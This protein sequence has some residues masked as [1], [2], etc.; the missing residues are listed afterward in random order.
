VSSFLCSWPDNDPASW[1]EQEATCATHAARLFAEHYC[2]RNN[3]C[4]RS[5]LGGELILVKS[6]G[7]EPQAFEVTVEMV[8]EFHARARK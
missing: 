4:Y 8:P 1:H 3:E 7:S 6:A 5:F 2:A